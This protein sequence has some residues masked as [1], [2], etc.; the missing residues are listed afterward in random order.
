MKNKINK[1]RQ[2]SDLRVLTGELD[3]MQQALF[4]YLRSFEQSMKLP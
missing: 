4:Y 3:R 2:S 1:T